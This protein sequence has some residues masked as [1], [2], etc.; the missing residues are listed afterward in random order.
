[1][2]R[3]QFQRLFH[4]SRRQLNLKNTKV[5]IVRK[6]T[7]TQFTIAF[8]ESDI[9]NNNDK[10]SILSDSKMTSA[11]RKVDLKDE[12]TKW[13]DQLPPSIRQV[14]ELMDKYKDNVVLT[15]MGSF[16]E[17][18]FEDA[19]KY[20]PNLNITL[21]SKTFASGKVPFAGFPVSQ[22]NRHLKVLVNQYGYS[23][24][25]VDQFKKEI[26]FNNDANKFARRVTRI[27]TPG[28]FIDEAF[29]N[30]REN[31]YLLTIEFPKNCM[32]KIADNNLNIGVSWC[33]VS[34][35]ELFVQNLHLSE[36]VSVITRIQPREILLKDDLIPYK[37][38]SGEW[39]P[40]LVELKKYFIKYHKP[41]SYYR[42]ISSF[43]SLFASQDRETQGNT[44][45]Q[46]NFIFETFEQ[47]ELAA[48]RNLLNYVSDH[49]P[50]FAINF[51][52]PNRQSVSS[53]MQIDSRTS[54][55]LELHSTVLNNSKKGSLLSSINRTVT[56]VGSRL[57]TQWLSG[58]TMDVKE[59]KKRQR[60]VNIFLS[61]ET[62]STSVIRY[63]KDIS[64]VSRIIQKFSFGKGTAI[65]I[66]QIAKSLKMALAISS[67]LNNCKAKVT[68]KR[69]KK[70]LDEM[71]Q[72]LQFDKNIIDDI[73]NSLNEDEIVKSMKGPDDNG[74]I[75]ESVD[76]IDEI[77]GDINEAK[78]GASIINPSFHPK[79]EKLFD[80]YW[81]LNQ[82]KYE[83]EKA[84]KSFF[85][86]SFDVKKVTLKQ[87][88]NKDY[89]IQIVGNA[90]QIKRLQSA[91]LIDKAFKY[92]ES[93]FYVLQKSS[94]TL[95]LTNKKWTDLAYSIETSLLHIKREEDNILASFKE[96]FV[97]K[98]NEIRIINNMLGYLDTLIS[99]AQLT[100]EKNLVCPTVSNDM[101]LNIVNGRHIMVEDGL[102]SKVLT[103]F[104]GNDCELNTGDVWIITGP[105]MGGKSTFLRQNAI[106]VI[107][108][109]IGCFVPCDSAQIGVVDKIFSRLGSADDLYNEMSTFMVEM[110]ETSFILR[111]A[112]N[113]S[114]AILDEIGRG[115]SGKEGIR[116][117][118]ATLKYLVEHNKCRTLFATHFGK[119]MKHIIEH[120][121]DDSNSTM[122]SQIKYC[123]SSTLQL[124]D[125][126][127]IY[128]YKLKPGI[129]EKSDA[130]NVARMAGFPIEALQVVE[131]LEN[132]Q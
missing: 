44:E 68:T 132:N 89:A 73:M 94:Q 84:M 32:E 95:W 101:S 43:K 103:K 48:L 33:D 26:A 20:A 27:V 61:N 82:N 12:K 102:A 90:E 54:R 93:S 57:L 22:L 115:T 87:R 118:F 92:D 124:Q 45:T 55:A 66:I 67:E 127:F 79:L 131:N 34:T 56:P 21:T 18:Y 36:L 70:L 105:N 77:P 91:I 120:Q 104:V 35:G 64:D 80:T 19:V 69:D 39:Y 62:V 25:I 117:A 23:V 9:P 14:R 114:L 17:L 109:Q 53:I 5:P 100:K 1:M 98:S 3:F 37:I 71:S 30:F 129:C 113:R 128:D 76:E 81:D 74:P 106:I 13:L 49:F 7:V 4:H 42:P 8:D 85:N 126:G 41:P 119:E 29:E 122:K 108:A 125:G 47:K 59:I 28:T 10:V 6:P 75:I 112:S 110:I 123:Q 96:K 83:L 121:N 63:L 60:I 38:E 31:T 46:L 116:I 58:P 52:L 88:Q 51:Q 107:L 99:F 40:E 2:K 15:Q 97:T 24:T 50:N 16:Y 11:I 72:E 78:Y 86:I 65:D 130:L 111:G